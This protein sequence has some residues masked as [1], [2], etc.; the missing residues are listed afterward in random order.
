[1]LYLFMKNSICLLKLT[2]KNIYLLKPKSYLARLQDRARH[3]TLLKREPLIYNSP[4]L[5][6]DSEQLFSTKVFS[7]STLRI[8]KP[9]TKDL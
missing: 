6:K 4:V 2:E 1:M 8:T 5:P 9:G 7:C 3:A